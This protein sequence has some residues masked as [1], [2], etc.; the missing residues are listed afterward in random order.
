MRSR[1]AKARAFS[2]I[3]RLDRRK[4]LVTS[5]SPVLQALYDLEY[6]A[7]FMTQLAVS[8]DAWAF[9]GALCITSRRRALRLRG[10]TEAPTSIAP[11]LELDAC[12]EHRWMCHSF[13][14]RDTRLHV[15]YAYPNSPKKRASSSPYQLKVL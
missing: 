7:S 4:S 2:Q 13:P 10:R 6:T 14:H 3:M 11:I 15:N 1:N 9:G 8:S 12:T 5:V